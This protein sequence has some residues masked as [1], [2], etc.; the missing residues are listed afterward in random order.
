MKKN[1]S[2]SVGSNEEESIGVGSDLNNIDIPVELKNIKLSEKDNTNLEKIKNNTNK[3]KIDKIEEN[4]V[5][6]DEKRKN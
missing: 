5:I 1:C 4:D 3:F 6:L 2:V